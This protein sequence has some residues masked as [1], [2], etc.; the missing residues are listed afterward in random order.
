MHHTEPGDEKVIDS[1]EEF[2]RFRECFIFKSIAHPRISILLQIQL[3]TYF[4]S[5]GLNP[6]KVMK[7]IEVLETESPRLL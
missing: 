5:G 3:F 6:F 4:S 7:E 2:N 1:T